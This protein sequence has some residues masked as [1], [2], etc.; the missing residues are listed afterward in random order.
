MPQNTCAINGI[1]CFHSSFK[2]KWD[3]INHEDFLVLLQCRMVNS[4]SQHNKIHIKRSI[5]SFYSI[6]YSKIH[7]KKLFREKCAKL[8]RIC[9][10]TKTRQSRALNAR[11]IGSN[12]VR[13]VL[14]CWCTRQKL[15]FMRTPNQIVIQDFLHSLS[16]SSC[17]VFGE[18]SRCKAP[19][20]NSEHWNWT[21]L[22]LLHSCNLVV[23][24][25]FCE[26]ATLAQMHTHR[27]G[28]KV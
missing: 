6:I 21:L 16:F 5:P 25:I 7:K 4:D 12:C 11:S 2:S 24:T 22:L 9:R 3:Q 26:H 18:C 8:H 23:G 13:V 27:N 14:L 15:H 19:C 17:G 28:V 1:V 20:E 10:K